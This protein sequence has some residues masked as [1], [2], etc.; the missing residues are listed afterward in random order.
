[1]VNKNRTT[2]L[3]RTYM[4]ENCVISNVQFVFQVWGILGTLF[5]V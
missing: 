1:M 5:P 3:H 4:N 2:Q